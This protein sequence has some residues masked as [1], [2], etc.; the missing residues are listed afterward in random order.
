[1]RTRR[2]HTSGPLR[3][4]LACPM[5]RTLL[6][7]AIRTTTS[8]ASRRRRPAA[9]QRAFASSSLRPFLI[10]ALLESA[11]FA[12]PAR[13]R[14]SPPTT[15]WPATWRSTCAPSSRPR[16][17]AS[18]RRAAFATS[19]TSRR[20]PHL[21]GPAHRSARLAARA[22]R[23]RAAGR[24]G[25]RRRAD[26]ADPRPGAAPARLRDRGRRGARPRRDA[27]AAGRVRLRARGAGRSSA[28]SSPCAAASSTS[29][30]RPRS[31]P[32]ASSCSATRSSRCAGSRRS[33]SARWPT[34]S[35]SRS[36]PPRSSSPSTA[37]SPRWRREEECRAAP[38]IA[39]VL[40][41]GPV[42]L[43]PRAGAG[44][45]RSRAWWP[46]R[47]SCGPAL[48]D[49]W[50]DVTTSLHSDDAHDLY[51][52]PDA[53]GEA[54][55][56]RAER[57]PVGGVRRPAAPV[58]RAGRRH[59]RAH[60]R[61]GRAGAGEARAL[62]LRRGRAPGTGAARPSAPPTTSR[63][64]GRSS[65]TTTST[66]GEGLWFAQAR[67]REGFIAPQ[68]KVAVIP[69]HRLLRRRRAERPE[70]TRGRAFQAFTELRPGDIVVHTD[71]GIG[72]FTGFDTKTVAERDAR[73]PRGRVPRRRPRLRP[74]RP[75]R[76]AEPLRRRRRRT[77][78]RS[79]SSARR[80]G[81]T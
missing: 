24:G 1:M 55:E 67:L 70:G 80:P 33:R 14:S 44:D 4:C 30:R 39:E 31:A 47:R 74:D 16:P 29:I 79:R 49:H 6:H 38:D 5:L 64:C 28:G 21:V 45:E 9:P 12:R 42:P 57:D 18:I 60:D 25:E 54:L 22:G 37:S 81:T 11:R 62:R 56:T 46:P 59:R 43:L 7:R 73:L 34:R 15:A 58:P 77:R 35:A 75:A 66:M 65:S 63:G 23:R 51:L 20:R 26:G 52:P 72:R 8:S 32:C 3:P 61:R 53:V 19:R 27:R 68:L 78:R 50:Q 41:G 10:A 71:H 2:T 13:A 36:R 69:D 17:C 40:P 76:P 48:A